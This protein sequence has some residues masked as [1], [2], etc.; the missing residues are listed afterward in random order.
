M[1]ARRCKGYKN[2]REYERTHHQLRSG[3]GWPR[4]PVADNGGSLWTP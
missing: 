2:G 1:A 4:P 3:D